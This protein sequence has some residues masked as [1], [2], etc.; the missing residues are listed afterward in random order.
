VGAQLKEQGYRLAVGSGSLIGW[1]TSHRRPRIAL[2]VAGD[3]M[4]ARNELLPDTR[5]EAALPLTVG[6]RLIGAL[7]VQS[8]ELN[9]FAQSD[10]DVLQVLADQIAVAVENV[11]LFARQ[12]RLAQ[13]EQRVAGM[14]ARIHQ[15]L[16][17][18]AILGN[19]ATEL[20]Q[21]FGARKVVVRLS[22]SAS[23]LTGARVAAAGAAP[24][25]FPSSNGGRPSNGSHSPET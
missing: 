7:D 9:A 16:T 13:L 3:E 11:R 5:S 21:A 8:Q 14:T 12:E 23:D 18:E 20:G 19:A 25:L 17:L 24:D 6:D 22:E 4:Y 1:V 10:I 15:S 2:D